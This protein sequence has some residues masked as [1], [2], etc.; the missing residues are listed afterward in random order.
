[1]SFTD[2]TDAET[3]KAIGYAELQALLGRDFVPQMIPS[4]DGR[5]M[6]FLGDV[7]AD[8]SFPTDITPEHLLP[9]HVRFGAVATCSDT[10]ASLLAAGLIELVD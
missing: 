9:D 2:D 3:L 10:P 6:R 1:M 7:E 8:H 5:G 4:E